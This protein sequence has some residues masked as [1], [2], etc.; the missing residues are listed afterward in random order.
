[1]GDDAVQWSEA[2]VLY[3]IRNYFINYV[4]MDLDMWKKQF[5]KKNNLITSLIHLDSN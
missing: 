4:D 1:M 3:K 2:A 5:L